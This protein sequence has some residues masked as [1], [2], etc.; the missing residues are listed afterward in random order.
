[1]IYV[2]QVELSPEKIA[3]I[4][5]RIQ[6]QNSIFK[7]KRYL[8]SLYL[9][10]K[11]M[12]R[13]KQAEQLIQ[14]FNSINEG[15]LVPV[16]SVYGR[17]GAGK[18]TIVK[19]VCENLSDIL[20][21]SFV[22]L[23][24]AKTVFGCANLILSELG[25]PNL[26][27][28]D[29]MNKVIDSV[30][31]RIEEI[32]EIEKKRFF[33]LVLD[34]YDVIFSDVRGQPSDFVYKLLNLEEN[35]REKG[36]WLCVITISNNSISDYDLDDRVKS[37][38]GNSEIFFNPYKEKDVF[39]ILFDRAKKA[40][41]KKIDDEV[42]RYCAK[43]SS[44]DHGDARRALDLLRVAAESC[45]GT[46]TKFD[47]DNAQE[48]VQGNKLYDVLKNASP[49]FKRIFLS[50][51]RISYLTEKK[52][53]STAIIYNQYQRFF[54]EK[55][56]KCLSYRRVFD[57]LAELEQAGLL[58]SKNESEGRY[59]YSKQYMLTIPAESVSAFSEKGWEKWKKIK[60][61]RFD[62]MYKPRGNNHQA[63]LAKYENMKIWYHLLGLD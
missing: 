37:R 62:M 18:S 11:I 40:F 27:S 60:K 10:S 45:D 1:V 21:S 2:L 61:A 55:D 28:A 35:L 59:G 15:L 13:E 29:G 49:N 42:L 44:T 3:Q 53:H 33:V 5:K 34:E 12:G 23:R 9:P 19:F 39:D 20:S 58:V 4:R 48:Q 32:L 56:R 31:K 54:M 17:S 26:K 63:K 6:K 43:L 14:H 51:T 30:E 24:K 52:W 38:M 22:N 57:I 47:I 41:V 46:I 50:I 36:I 7:E 25:L 16:I 8:D